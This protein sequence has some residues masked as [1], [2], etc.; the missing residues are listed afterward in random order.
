MNPNPK[1]PK[2]RINPWTLPVSSQE[3]IAPVQVS[4]LADLP[5]FR[6]LIEPKESVSPWNNWQRILKRPPSGERLE[7]NA[8]LLL[9]EPLQPLDQPDYPPE[10]PLQPPTLSPTLPEPI[11]EPEEEEPALALDAPESLEATF[12]PSPLP[13]ESADLHLPIEVPELRPLPTG[14]MESVPPPPDPVEMPAILLPAPEA[15]RPATLHPDPEPITEPEPVPEALPE[16]PCQPEPVRMEGFMAAPQSTPEQAPPLE[17]E[18]PSI[19]TPDP[20]RSGEPKPLRISI[21]TAQPEGMQRSECWSASAAEV[22]KRIDHEAIVTSKR[23]PTVSE[24][25]PPPPALPRWWMGGVALL[26][27]IGLSQLLGEWNEAKVPAKEPSTPVV[28]TTVESPEPEP[29]PASKPAVTEESPPP[30]ADSVLSSPVSDSPPSTPTPTGEAAAQSQT[31]AV[32]ASVEPPKASDGVASHKEADSAPV[33]SLPAAAATAS[34]PGTAERGLSTTSEA[35][36]V[37]S[38]VK[39]NRVRETKTRKPIASA[40]KAQKSRHAALA[41]RGKNTPRSATLAD[42]PPGTS[43]SITSADSP[44]FVVSY[45]CFASPEEVERRQAR[46]KAKRWPV[47]FTRYSIDRTIMTCVY[48]GPF[49]TPREAQQAT[50]LFEEKGCLQIPK[51]PLSINP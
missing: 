48:S 41:S 28:A 35:K 2:L 10:E 51:T 15:E 42:L 22:E 37:A 19:P 38:R 8:D 49:I 27:V 45:G 23:M 44:R 11:P 26:M 16:S 30:P 50:E 40:R 25:I 20:T 36:R 31:A 46:I 24:S 33:A 32:A 14:E 43:A 5:N 9:P 18:P 12:I 29:S 17:P 13:P 6:A 21:P 3:P 34:L 4:D 7:Q 47:A 39:P 1:S